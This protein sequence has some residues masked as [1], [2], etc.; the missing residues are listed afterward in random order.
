MPYYIEASRWVVQRTGSSPSR[1]KRRFVQE[2]QFALEL[3]GINGVT[4]I[5]AGAVL[6]GGD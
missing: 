4:A 3:A 6:D 1:G 5:V 2:P